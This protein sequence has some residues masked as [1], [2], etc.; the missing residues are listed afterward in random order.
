MNKTILIG[1][2]VADPEAR[3]TSNGVS[4]TTFRVAVTRNRDRE[5][6]DFFEIVTWRGLADICSKYLNKGKKVAIIGEIQNR[7]YEAKDGTKR[8]ITEII[9]DEVEFLTKS[10]NHEERKEINIQEAMQ[11]FTE[12][13]DEQLPF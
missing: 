12:I 13:E 8:Y 10:G 11:G 6:S 1:N 4:V 2:L 5:K 7:S 3:T 9:A